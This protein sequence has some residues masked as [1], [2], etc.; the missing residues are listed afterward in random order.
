MPNFDGGHYF[1]TALIPI[2][3][4]ILVEDDGMR[5]SPVQLVRHA[6]ATLPTALQT[7]ATEKIGINSPFARNTRTHLSR[8]VVINDVMYNARDPV[9]AIVAADLPSIEAFRKARQKSL[10][11]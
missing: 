11:Y 2:K 8:F 6:L 5:R 1:L 7:Q 10:L 9:D 3:T 4:G